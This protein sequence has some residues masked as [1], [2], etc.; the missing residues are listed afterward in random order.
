MCIGL[1]MIHFELIFNGALSCRVSVS[2]NHNF[3]STLPGPPI[4]TWIELHLL[5]QSPF[6]NDKGRMIVVIVPEVVE[7]W[8]RHKQTP[9]MYGI[10]K[11]VQDELSHASS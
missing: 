9:I 2:E 10:R 6:D 3:D 4:K 1:Q 5:A 11:V 8:T 7:L